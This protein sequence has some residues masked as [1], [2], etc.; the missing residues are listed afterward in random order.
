MSYP[1]I[2]SDFTITNPTHASTTRS[3]SFIFPSK[4]SSRRTLKLRRHPKEFQNS[5]SDYSILAHCHLCWD[6]VWQRPQQ[7]LS[8]L[9]RNRKVIFVETL[10]PDP[11]IAVPSARPRQVEEFP[12]LTILSVQ[13]PSSVWSDGHF[14][15]TERRRLVQEFLRKSCDF[16]PIVQWFYDPMAVSAFVGYVGEVLTVYDCMDELSKFRF[17]PSEIIDRDKKLLSRADVVFTGGWKLLQTKK[18]FNSN[19]HFYGC[20]VDV[21]HFGKAREEQTIVPAQLRGI[22][23]PLQLK[24]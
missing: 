8:R 7:F 17:A 12:N 18:R 10:S 13:F 2:L 5:A 24:F 16:G 20:G 3:N 1:P 6:W 21:Q 22:K 11:S 9:S 19:C 14:V 23:N 15:D 4:T